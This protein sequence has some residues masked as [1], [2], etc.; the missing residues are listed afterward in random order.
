MFNVKLI[1]SNSPHKTCAHR[2]VL[3]GLKTK[4]NDYLIY[5]VDQI[6]ICKIRL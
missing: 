2:S 6:F 5:N 1:C 4:L 3:V